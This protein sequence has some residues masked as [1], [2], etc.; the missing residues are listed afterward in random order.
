MPRLNRRTGVVCEA[1]GSRCKLGG[2]SGYVSAF[3]L[4]QPPPPCA[5]HGTD[6]QLGGG[7]RASLPHCTPSTRNLAEID[8]ELAAIVREGELRARAEADG[9]TVPEAEARIDAERR[10]WESLPCA[11]VDAELSARWPGCRTWP[12][13]EA[14]RTAAVLAEVE[15]VLAAAEAARPRPEP[16]PPSARRPTAERPQERPT[17]PAEPPLP[18]DVTDLEAARKRWRRRPSIRV[19]DTWD[20]DDYNDPFRE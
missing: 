14:A 15:T 18:P 17:T 7:R 13:V 9:I 16:T 12:Q 3:C 11:K 10:R 4:R 5:I 8:P 20:D 1:H 6:C 19:I 2:G